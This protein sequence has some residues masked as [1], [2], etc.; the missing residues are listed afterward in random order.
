ME[1]LVLISFQMNNSREM[2]SYEGVRCFTVKQIAK[3]LQVSDR[4]VYNNWRK[5]GGKKLVG[6][7][8]FDKRIVER[9]MEAN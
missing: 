6:K 7:I 8:R 4:W 9:I 2:N 1:I 5:L 3:M